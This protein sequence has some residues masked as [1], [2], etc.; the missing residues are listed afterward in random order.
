MQGIYGNS[1]EIKVKF[2]EIFEIRLRP[3]KNINQ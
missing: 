1:V 3:R 2:F